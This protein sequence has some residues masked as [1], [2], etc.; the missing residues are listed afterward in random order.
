[1]FSVYT[2]PEKLKNV[3]IRGHL[4]IEFVEGKS[5]IYHDVIVFEMEEFINA[6]FFVHEK[7][8][9]INSSILK[10]VLGK[11]RFR[12]GLVWTVGLTVEIKLCFQIP[13]V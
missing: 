13:P 4:A 2:T 1:M 3:T 11:L 5:H 10:N 9:F 12:D 8:A 6:G 7:P